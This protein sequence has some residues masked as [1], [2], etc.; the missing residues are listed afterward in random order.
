MLK[1]CTTYRDVKKSK[2][3]PSL[4]QAD[5]SVWENNDNCGSIRVHASILRKEWE[6]KTF[7]VTTETTSKDLIKMV[8]YKYRLET[9]DPNLYYLT[10][11]TGI[12]KPDPNVSTAILLEDDTKPLLLQ[13]CQPS[14]TTRFSLKIKRGAIIKVY[15]E[16]LD[17]EM[18]YKTM[19]V[20]ESTHSKEI[21]RL[22][23]LKYKCKE[24]ATDFQLCEYSV[25]TGFTSMPLRAEYLPL[26]CSK[27][28][29]GPKT[30]KLRRRDKSSKCLED[31][32]NYERREDK[33]H[34]AM[35]K[36]Q[37]EQY[38]KRWVNTSQPVNA[39]YTPYT[40]TEGT[41]GHLRK[42]HQYVKKGDPIAPKK[43][44]MQIE[45]QECMKNSKSFSHLDQ[46]KAPPVTRNDHYATSYSK[47]N[48]STV[49]HPHPENAR[50]RQPIHN[51]LSA[52]SS[53]EDDKRQ[54]YTVDR[55]QSLSLGAIERVPSVTS[56]VESD[57]RHYTVDRTNSLP[58]NSI[59]GAVPGCQD[60]YVQNALTKTNM[61]VEIRRNKNH[62][63]EANVHRK[64][65]PNEKVRP[66][67]CY[68]DFSQKMHNINTDP[69]TGLRC[70]DGVQPRESHIVNSTQVATIARQNSTGM[71]QSGFRPR[72][73]TMPVKT[74]ESGNQHQD[75][76]YANEQVVDICEGPRKPIKISRQPVLQK[77]PIPM[78]RPFEKS[79][80]KKCQSLPHFDTYHS[81]LKPILETLH[82]YTILNVVVLRRHLNGAHR[83]WG[84]RLT[85][86][87][88]TSS[89]RPTRRSVYQS[90][91]TSESSM[92]TESDT[93]TE[94]AGGFVCVAE[95]GRNL[96]G[97]QSDLQI[98][99]LIL[100]V[101]LFIPD[102]RSYL[103][104]MQFRCCTDIQKTLYSARTRVT[105]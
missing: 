25:E 56:S 17:P 83:G 100:Q 81:S 27:K 65:I 1:H 70:S 15:G 95:L 105:S 36:M 48:F 42:C 11:E 78:V 22:S 101:R 37:K 46:N 71:P 69:R 26:S 6:Y 18:P 34:I 104:F 30:F 88:V 99:D 16:I 66:R 35:V 61:H 28:T 73:S 12:S 93:D 53:V 62:I 4:A 75:I 87:S 13:M 68:T 24:Q 52:A 2:S 39:H 84:I 21:V 51:Y 64:H 55:T 50:T 97:R 79:T 10:M 41:N 102:F 8:L 82:G 44:A 7:V 9:H 5:D 103:K 59:E 31:E 92:E 38:I 74:F 49:Y 76:K 47:T 60:H 94:D 14:E 33:I 23:L 32:E 86:S 67:S 85:V 57:M 91:T 3:L 72:C 54:H 45:K 90:S 89:Q 77:R 63:S 43:T 80:I 40:S 19:H 96:I 20:C 98:G 29:P 58:S